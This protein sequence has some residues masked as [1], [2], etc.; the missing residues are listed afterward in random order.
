MKIQGIKNILSL[1]LSVYF[2]TAGMGYNV[3]KYCC[4][5][6]QNAGIEKVAEGACCEI[7]LHSNSKPEIK[8]TQH[9]DFA[10]DDVHHITSEC[11]LLRL[12]TDIPAIDNCHISFNNNDFEIINL[13]F[14]TLSS[15]I[16]SSYSPVK[17]GIQPPD[18]EYYHNGRSIITLH[19]VLLI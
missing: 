4:D 13:Q 17:S 18:N 7:H 12:N 1:F 11:H 10:C 3:V 19:S 16:F 2:C 15:F 5:S 8:E 14:I 6:C 9:A